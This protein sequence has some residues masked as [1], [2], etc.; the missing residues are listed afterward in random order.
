MF[1]YQLNGKR[2]RRCSRNDDDELIQPDISINFCDTKSI[3]LRLEAD[4]DSDNDG[5]VK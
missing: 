2:K 3:A 1:N 4:L 5:D